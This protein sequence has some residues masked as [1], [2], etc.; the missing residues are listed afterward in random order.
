MWRK[1]RIA[2]VALALVL[3]LAPAAPR[4]QDAEPEAST[5]KKAIAYAGCIGS[6]VLLPLTVAGVFAMTIACANALAVS[7]EVD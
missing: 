1:T 7:A 2:V 4:A 3:A 5:V 6:V